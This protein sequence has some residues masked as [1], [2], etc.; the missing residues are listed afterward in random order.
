MQGKREEEEEE[1]E[2]SAFTPNQE[3]REA[4]Y[5]NKIVWPSPA[6]EVI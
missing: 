4:G 5:K 3:T 1:A 6:R 2:Y